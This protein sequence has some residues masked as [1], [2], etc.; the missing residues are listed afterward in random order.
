MPPISS[1][2]IELSGATGTGIGSSYGHGHSQGT[3][4]QQMIGCSENKSF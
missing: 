3:I 1:K 4:Y 2:I